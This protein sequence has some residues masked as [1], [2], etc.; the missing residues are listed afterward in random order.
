MSRRKR[1]ILLYGTLA[2]F[3]VLS[4]VYLLLPS[5]L[6]LSYVIDSVHVAKMEPQGT[7][8]SMTCPQCGSQLERI[9]IYTSE[10][11]DAAWR[12]AFYCGQEDVFWVY[13][14]PGGTSESRV[15]G[16]FNAY[17]KITDAAAIGIII[18]CS[19]TL[20]LMIARKH[21]KTQ[22]QNSVRLEVPQSM[23]PRQEGLT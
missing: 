9:V 17:W 19:V 7:W 4:V 20:V 14:F 2:A 22:L 12:F 21:P 10:Y 23:L 6:K 8:V 13:D 11:T 5:R 15:Y 1:T 16:P 3:L 18:I